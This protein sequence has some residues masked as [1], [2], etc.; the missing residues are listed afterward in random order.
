MIYKLF[1]KVSINFIIYRL[2]KLFYFKQIIK[3]DNFKFLIDKKLVPLYNLKGLIIRFQD[4]EKDEKKIIH[5]FL[6]PNNTLELGCSIGV[7]SLYIKKIILDYNL[8][9][10]DA[11]KQAIEY[12]K[13][14]FELNRIKNFNFIYHSIGGNGFKVDSSN[15]LSS[16]NNYSNEIN[17]E[18]SNKFLNELIKRHKIKNLVID[19]EGMEEF[20]FYIL[21]LKKIEVII[22]EFHPNLY[23][24]KTKEQLIAKIESQNFLY[25]YKINENYCFKK[26]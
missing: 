20:I 21:D 12:C 25:K 17:L 18:N 1:N 13:T 5:K 6:E 3:R 4:H 24:S 26:N 16:R 15:F 10:I 9:S 8:I 19:I 14:I 22:I 23:I 7:L 11:N 2:H